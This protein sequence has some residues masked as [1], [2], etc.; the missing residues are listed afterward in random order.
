[1][2][3]FL[4]INTWTVLFLA[5]FW[6]NVPT[7]FI[8][9][10]YLNDNSF[11]F[12]I[13]F[14]DLAVKL[15]TCIKVYGMFFY[16]YI[17]ALF[18][19][20]I[21]WCNDLSWFIPHVYHDDRTHFFS[22]GFASGMEHMLQNLW[23]VFLNIYT[24]TVFLTIFWSNELTWFIPH[25]YHSGRTHTFSFEFGSETEHMLKNLCYVFFVHIPLHF[26]I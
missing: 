21:F 2:V 25:V 13:C 26:F 22:F 18:Y 14:L 20:T 6:C 15:S 19:L 4:Y 7:W 12:L 8:P 23:Y 17:H 16:T 5:K 1:M 10:V 9:H 24:S 3:F 11:L